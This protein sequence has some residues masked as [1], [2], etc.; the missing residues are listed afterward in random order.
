LQDS[1]ANAGQLLGNLLI[2]L[3]LNWYC[4][5]K[6]E[7]KLKSLICLTPNI[8]IIVNS[9]AM[10]KEQYENIA[11]QQIKNFNGMRFCPKCF[12]LI[13]PEFGS[14]THLYFKCRSCKSGNI[15]AIDL[16]NADVED[17][18]IRQIQMKSGTAADI[19]ERDMPLDPSMPRKN[20]RCPKCDF[21]QA[22]YYLMTD[23]EEKRIIIQY[24]CAR[25]DANKLN[26][27]CGFRFTTT[28]PQAK[29]LPPL[30][31]GKRD[32]PIAL[33]AS[34]VKQRPVL[35]GLSALNIK[36]ESVKLES[37]DE[38]LDIFNNELDDEE[39]E[40]VGKIEEEEEDEDVEND[41]FS[42]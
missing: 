6:D 38:Q 41:L 17:H 37:L 11:V 19:F 40:D 8:N 22:V 34:S 35:P 25:L 10:H 29:Q 24:I 16:A 15:I 5:A 13:L 21:N 9:R 28:E 30:G 14:G 2:Y 33:Q 4:F 27:T 31:S 39:N 26:V 18:M 36:Q 23:S 20:I 12:N 3:Y 1:P 32:E 42:N 7:A